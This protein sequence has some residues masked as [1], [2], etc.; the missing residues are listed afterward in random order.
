MLIV[1]T[2][3]RIR[4]EHFLK[5]KSIKE[6]ARD[7]K[8]S[9]NTVR[10]VLRSGETSFSYER[11]IQPRPKL[12]RWQ[13]EID[14]MLTQNTRNATRERLT[15]IRLFEE[16]RALGYEGGYDAL[17]R[18]QVLGPRARQPDG[19]RLRSLIVC[20]RRS[21]SVRLEPR[22]R[23]VERRDRDLEGRACPPLP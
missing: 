12:G 15:L 19:E 13:V 1:E 9:R 7:L 22:D 8:I 4:R 11:E 23:G 2:I 17:R 5:G 20:P 18:C 10:R 16:L 21:L 6:I 3:G 14:R